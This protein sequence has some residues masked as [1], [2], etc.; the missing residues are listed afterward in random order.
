MG[1][2]VTGSAGALTLATAVTTTAPVDGEGA[3]A[4]S[5]VTLVQNLA[6]WIDLL[7]AKVKAIFDGTQTLKSV[8]VDGT[9]QASATASAGD[10]T[11]SG[12]THSPRYRAIGSALASGDFALGSGWGTTATVTVATGSCDTAGSITVLCQGTGIAANPR[13][14][15]TFKNGTFPANGAVQL[16]M[17]T[18]NDES[19]NSGPL[20]HVVVKPSL[21]APQWFMVGTPL[22]GKNY[23]FK[24]VT[25]SL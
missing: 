14:I 5:Q 20:Y 2:T 13:I 16:V 6:N 21:T 8:Q 12:V 18:D 17:H 22:T 10:I 4:A 19:T 3:N 24:W 15:L 25:V 7:R 23:T 1:Q 9:G 11:A